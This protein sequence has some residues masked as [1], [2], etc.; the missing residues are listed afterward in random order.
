MI[1]DQSLIDGVPLCWLNLLDTHYMTTIISCGNVGVERLVLIM[2]KAR[3]LRTEGICSLET[4]LS[5]GSVFNLKYKLL[6]WSGAITKANIDDS[7]AVVGFVRFQSMA[8]L[9]FIG[10]TLRREWGTLSQE[11]ICD[12]LSTPSYP[13]Y[14]PLCLLHPEEFKKNFGL[15]CGLFKDFLKRGNFKRVFITG[16]HGNE[17]WF[18]EIELFL[19]KML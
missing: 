7:D 19:S 8:H 6:D 5:I 14:K 13:C 15:Y 3:R 11:E 2:A 18:K 17:Y 1:D 9:H 10:Y 4:K 12:I 16:H